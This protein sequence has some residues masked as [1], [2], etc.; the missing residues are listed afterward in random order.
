MGNNDFIPS[1]SY[2]EL[3]LD[4]GCVF[5]DIIKHEFMHAMGFQH[6]QTRAD[7][8]DYVYIHYDNI[9]EG[10]FYQY[11]E[12]DRAV[13]LHDPPT[14]Q[15]MHIW[16]HSRWLKDISHFPRRYIS[17]PDWGFGGTWGNSQWGLS[18]GVHGEM[19]VGWG[20]FTMS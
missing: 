6:E 1:W 2:Q 8:D 17:P 9:P 7:R 10:K 4:N 3:S 12:V 5:S 11:R 19:S 20:E 14:P 18:R 16:I 15:P 13:L